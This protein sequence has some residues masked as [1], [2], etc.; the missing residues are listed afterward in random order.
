MSMTSVAAGLFPSTFLDDACWLVDGF[1]MVKTED[2][3]MVWAIGS[4]CVDF[5]SFEGKGV[6]CFTLPLYVTR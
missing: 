2:I 6:I 5:V 1:A 3:L 4:V